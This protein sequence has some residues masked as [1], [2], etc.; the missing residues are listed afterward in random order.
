[1][2]FKINNMRIIVP[3]DPLEGERYIEHVKEE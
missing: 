3:L 1:M 2:I